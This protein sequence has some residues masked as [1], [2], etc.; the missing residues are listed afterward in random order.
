[1]LRYLVSSTTRRK[2]LEVLFCD[3]AR[4]TAA[5]LAR[6]ASVPV[7]A[8]YGELHAM[9]EAGLATA[10]VESGHRVYEANARS[11]HAQA[12]RQ[13]ASAPLPAVAAG[14]SLSHAGAAHWDRVRSELALRGAPLWRV[15]AD[16][17]PTTALE[18]LL[19][20][21]CELSRHD[22]SVAKVLPHLFV[23]KRD[24][25]DFE[26]FAAA[27]AE[28]NQK[29]AAGFLLAVAAELSG[30]EQLQAWSSRLQDRR[31]KKVQNFFSGVQSPRLRA[32]AERN[33]PQLAKRWHYRM[34]M[35]MDDFRSVMEKFS[36]HDALPG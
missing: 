8:T 35:A 30:D 25:L 11:T 9:T 21:A 5:S 19:A 17:K 13:L 16:T 28:R 3:G 36:E 34:N 20:E 12:L 14:A 1:M 15:T 27:L 26:R 29:H 4:G 22:P 2:L 33:T 7:G 24:E 6:A 32:L 18:Q 10:T 23:Q 31:R